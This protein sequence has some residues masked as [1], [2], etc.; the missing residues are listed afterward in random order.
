MFLKVAE[1]QAIS[2]VLAI[3]QDTERPKTN[4]IR[5]VQTSCLNFMYCK[6]KSS[7]LICIFLSLFP[8]RFH[9]FCWTINFQTSPQTSLQSSLQPIPTTMRSS[10]CL[11][12]EVFLYLSHIQYAATVWSVC[13]VQMWT[14]YVTRVLVLMSTRPSPAHL[15]LPSPARIPSSQ[16]FSLAGN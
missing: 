4:D 1:P 12:S 14:A 11:C 13:P 6:F 5:S 3:R 2:C 10:N 15:S 16:L 8:D 9:H 7:P